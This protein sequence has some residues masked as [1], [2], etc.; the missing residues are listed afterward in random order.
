MDFKN[1]YYQ[2]LIKPDLMPE[3][4]VFTTVW[5]ILY[6]L[7]AISLI[8][9]LTKKN[10][11]KKI[12]LSLFFTQILVNLSW[13]FVFFNFNEIFFALIIL[14]ALIILVIL[15]TIFFFRI[16]KIAGFLLVPYILWLFCAF[17]LNYQIIILNP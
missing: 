12:A 6:I 2:N 13:P 4:W 8:I 1:Y 15:T 5:T 17:Y 7:M 9:I 11:Y 14:I 10:K 3:A 16:S